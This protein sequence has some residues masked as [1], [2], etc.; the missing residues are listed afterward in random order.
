MDFDILFGILTALFKGIPY[1]AG[2]QTCPNKHC[3]S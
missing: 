3:W 2:V 1:A